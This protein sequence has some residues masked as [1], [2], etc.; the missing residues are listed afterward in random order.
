MNECLVK[1]AKHLKVY[2][3][4]LECKTALVSFYGRFGFKVDEGN[5]FMVQRINHA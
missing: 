1:L 5:N 4:S 3:L 2:K